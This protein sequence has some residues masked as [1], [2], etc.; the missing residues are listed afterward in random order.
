MA[1]GPVNGERE[2][3]QQKITDRVEDASRSNFEEH[4]VE[5]DDEQMRQ[6]LIIENIGNPVRTP[7]ANDRRDFRR[8]PALR[9]LSGSVMDR[10][11]IEAWDRAE[12]SAAA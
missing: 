7:A 9:W 3:D 11:V 8:G 6:V 1:H 2:A 5:R 10:V 12:T 4:M